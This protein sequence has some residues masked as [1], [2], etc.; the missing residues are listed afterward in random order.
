MAFNKAC[1]TSLEVRLSSL[2]VRPESLTYVVLLG[3]ALTAKVEREKALERR[4]VATNFSLPAGP[5]PPLPPLPPPRTRQR[6]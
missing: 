5:P 4:P 6:F 2:T 1:S 3:R